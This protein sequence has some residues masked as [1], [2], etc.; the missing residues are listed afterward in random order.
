[1]AVNADTSGFHIVDDRFWSGTPPE[2]HI[3]GSGEGVP[4]S[5]CIHIVT[6]LSGLIRQRFVCFPIEWNGHGIE[7]RAPQLPVPTIPF[8]CAQLIEVKSLCTEE[9]STLHLTDL[10]QG[11]LFHI[12]QP[13]RGIGLAVALYVGINAA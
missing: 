2:E 10:H 5:L 9:E 7:E 13:Q 6:S 8:G 11:V 12:A 3:L 1:M 4:E